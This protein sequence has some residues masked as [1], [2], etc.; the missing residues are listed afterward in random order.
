MSAAPV[1]ACFNLAM[2][3]FARVFRFLEGPAAKGVAEDAATTAERQQLRL[4][5]KVQRQ[6]DT[7]VAQAQTHLGATRN[8]FAQ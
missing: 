3:L 6:I 4:R 8:A 5:T 1:T 2:S 7:K